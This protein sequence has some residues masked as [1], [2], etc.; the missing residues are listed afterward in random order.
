MKINPATNS[1]H[2]VKKP[3]KGPEKNLNYQTT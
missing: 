1:P 2:V 3:L